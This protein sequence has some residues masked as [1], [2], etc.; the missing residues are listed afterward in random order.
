[1]H[2]VRLVVA[3]H[4]RLGHIQKPACQRERPDDARK[5]RPV[6]DLPAGLLDG[7][8]VELR[9]PRAD[10][11]NRKRVG[12]ILVG[13]DTIFIPWACL[14]LSFISSAT[15][16]PIF[17][18]DGNESTGMAFFLSPAITDATHSF[19]FM[20]YPSFCLVFSPMII[21]YLTI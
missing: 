3:V 14:S 17:W 5:Y 9:A 10:F 21:I 11:R 4:K 12:L 7:V 13:D 15:V 8:D 1:M 18:I 20:E 16:I 19:M 6:R 2:H